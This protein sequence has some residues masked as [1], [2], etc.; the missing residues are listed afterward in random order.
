MVTGPDEYNVLVDDNAYTNLMAR[1]N[2]RYAIQTVERVREIRSD[3]FTAL[4]HRTQLELSE[5]EE[6]KRKAQ[7]MYIPY[8]SA[9]GIT[10]QD[11]RFLEQER[12]DFEHTSPDKYPLLLF[13]HPLTIY[14]RQVVKQADVVLAMLLLNE[15][16]S[17]ELKK[18]NFEFYDPLT[19]GD[20]SLSACIQSIMAQEVGDTEKALEYA[21]VATL[22]DLGDVAGNVK[23][24]CHI[25][26][27][28][29]VWMIFVYG[30]AGMRDYGGDLRFHPSLPSGLERVRFRLIVRDQVVEVELGRDTTRYTLRAGTGLTI[31]HEDR[32]VPLGEEL[33]SSLQE[34]RTRPSTS[35][36]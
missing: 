24:G 8:D 5:L 21:R 32:E 7:N 29:G 35:T 12:W 19:T 26:A 17:P 20:S 3:L 27:M 33:R 13:F 31:W 23:D 10:P 1:E 11:A 15:E 22:M 25:A 14:R 6:W 2:L 30:F 36:S 28:G 9:L 34:N 18:R 16:F 4:V